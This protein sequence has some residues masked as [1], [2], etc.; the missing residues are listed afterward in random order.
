MA[1]QF[2]PEPGTIV[3]CDFDGLKAPEITKRRPAIVMSPRFRNRG[4]LCTV[5]PLSTTAPQPV[6]PYHFRLYMEQQLPYPFAADMHWIKAD[7][8]YTVSFERL[9]LPFA[10][11]DE[12]G[13][14]VYDVRVIEPNELVAIRRCLL[15]GLGL[16][17]LTEHLG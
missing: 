5:V 1:I 7:M 12:L 10:G 16:S 17:A 2:H 11:K 6:M 8:V 14:R 13:R 4:N 9:F 15:H 3:I